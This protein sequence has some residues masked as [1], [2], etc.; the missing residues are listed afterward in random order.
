MKK[1]FISIMAVATMLNLCACSKEFN[2]TPD[3]GKAIDFDNVQTRGIV[4]SADELLSMGVFAQRNDKAGSNS[5][6]MIL[7]N[8]K[9]YRD[10]VGAPWTYEN[11]RY[12]ARDCEYHFF[13]VWPYS[14]E[15]NSPVSKVSSTGEGDGAYG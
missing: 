13:A 7:E 1:I 10:T 14:G 2:D 3:S 5:Y 12:W 15:K 9:V 11:T 6:K 8:E 4:T